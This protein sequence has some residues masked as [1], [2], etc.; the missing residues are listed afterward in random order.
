MGDLVVVG[1]GLAQVLALLLAELCQVRV[2]DPLVLKA[3]VVVALCVTDQVDDGRHFEKCSC[4]LTHAFTHSL[5]L[6]LIDCTDDVDGGKKLV[7]DK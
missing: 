4:C 5:S 3:E 7:F 1:E 2:A 6:L